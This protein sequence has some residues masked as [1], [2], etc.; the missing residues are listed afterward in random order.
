VF[1]VEQRYIKYRTFTFTSLPFTFTFFRCSDLTLLVNRQ[2][3]QMG[4]VFCG[5]ETALN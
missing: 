2:K 3:G 5:F 1:I 4:Q